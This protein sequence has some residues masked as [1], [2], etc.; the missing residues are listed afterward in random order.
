M[1]CVNCGK[2]GHSFRECREPTSSFG[3]VAIRMKDSKPEYLLIRRRDSL[4]YVD[5]LRGKYNLF[6]QSYIQ[7]LLNQMTVEERYRLQTQSFDTLWTNLWN[8]Q[9]T[10]QYRS[11]YEHAK[12][13]FEL[14]KSTGDIHGKL[15]HRYIA[16]VSTEWKEPEWGFPKG[17]RSPHE[18]ES[19]CAVREFCEETGLHT[20]DIWIRSDESPETEEYCGT[21]GILYKHK[22]F[23]GDCSTDVSVSAT[24]RVQTREVGDIGWFSFEDAYLKIRETNPEKRAVLGRVH[25]RVLNLSSQ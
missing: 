18:S 3:I 2:T 13:T 17:R 7:T 24:N 10:R 15:L 9:N 21:N 25:A 16:D 8:S 14:I 4:G 1:E 5:F 19:D 20:K 11:E 12:K 23:L 6:D 22:Y